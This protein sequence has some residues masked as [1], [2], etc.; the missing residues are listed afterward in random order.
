M[1]TQKYNGWA[2]YATWIINLEHFDN[3]EDELDPELAEEIV[4]ERIYNA[5]QEGIA[6]DYA[7]AFID[8]VDWTE[9]ALAHCPSYDYKWR[10]RFSEAFVNAAPQGFDS[11]ADTQTDSPWQCPWEWEAYEEWALDEDPQI[12]G[13]KF[14]EK[15]YSELEDLIEEDEELEI[16]QGGTL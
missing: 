14:A 8:Y 2:N 1:D 13:K 6:R 10:E 15:V 5:S 9:I 12:A 16:E 4:T 11:E 3:W 7:L